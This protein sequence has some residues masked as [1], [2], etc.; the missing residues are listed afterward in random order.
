MKVV[1][2]TNIII[3]TLLSPSRKS[4][5]FRATEMCLE[6]SIEPQFGNALFT[7]YEDVSRRQHILDKTKFTQDEITIYQISS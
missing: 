5:S 7:E 4:A 2:D 1:I 3:N 6:G